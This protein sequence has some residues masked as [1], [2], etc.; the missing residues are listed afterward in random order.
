MIWEYKIV[1]FALEGTDEDDYEERL[2]EG[3][4]LLDKFG[5]E[6]WELIAFL[7][8]RMAGNTTRHHAVFKR[9]KG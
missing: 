8:H 4:H 9:P 1:Y 7:P 3:A 6:G 2:H 5:G